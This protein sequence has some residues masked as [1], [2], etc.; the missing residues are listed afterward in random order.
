MSTH[1]NPISQTFFHDFYT[2][3]LS[4]QDPV[5]DILIV[6]DSKGSLGVESKST[7]CIVRFFRSIF[8]GTSYNLP[9]HVKKIQQAATQLLQEAASPNM[10]QE[11]VALS[12]TSRALKQIVKHVKDRKP[13][14]SS[15]E[16]D[17][18]TKQYAS[19]RQ[20]AELL[21]ISPHALA[22]S[23][24]MFTDALHFIDQTKDLNDVK[25]HFPRLLH[26]AIRKGKSDKAT[27]L[28]NQGAI[29][30]TVTKEDQL[31]YA[32]QTANQE[33][34]CRLIRSGA[35]V[36]ISVYKQPILHFACEKNYADVLRALLHHGAKPDQVD[37][38]GQIPLHLVTRAENK[39]LMTILL[40]YDA[41]ANAADKLKTGP[42]HIATQKSN[43]DLVELLLCYRANP[44]KADR[45][46][47]TAL[48]FAA[49]GQNLEIVKLLLLNGANINAQTT[50]EATALHCAA[51]KAS[52][53]IC[54]HLLA[55]GIDHTIE[56]VNG[57]TAL[58]LPLDRRYNL[59]NEAKKRF[60]LAFFGHSRLVSTWLQ[61]N[62]IGY[63][64]ITYLTQ[65][66]R[67]LV[68]EAK[69][70]RSNPYEF[71]FI[72]QDVGLTRAISSTMSQREF[73]AYLESL[74]K[75]HPNSSMDLIEFSPFEINPAHFTKGNLNIRVPAP[76]RN[77][78]L[79]GFLT[80]FDEL[81]TNN[82]DAQ[83]FFDLHKV[84]IDA[85]TSN[86]ARLREILQAMILKVKNRTAFLGTPREGSPALQEFY[87]NIDN[88]LKNILLKLE[89]LRAR[90]RVAYKALQQAVMFDILCMMN[91]CGGRYFSVS[92]CG[93]L[94]FAR[95][96][97]LTFA[98]DIYQSLAD[99]REVLMQATIP[100]GAHS[101]HDYNNLVRR[102]GRKYGLPGYQVF[103]SFDDPFQHVDVARS[104][105]QFKKSY[106]TKA[107]VKEWL[108]GTFTEGT[109]RE[110]YIDWQ[111]SQNAKKWDL[112][113]YAPIS[114]HVAILIQEKA[115]R[116]TIID[117]LAK[118]DI[119]VNGSDQNYQQAIDQDQ[120][121]AYIAANIMDENSG[122][123][124]VEA[125]YDMLVQMQ[126]LT[127]YFA[128]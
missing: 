32:M 5:K 37:S 87:Q 22:C 58:R 111:K 114:A 76:A 70:A 47:Y 110:K 1:F 77:I 119:V 15:A 107:I 29:L 64:F 128:R 122:A 78:P 61:S 89:E 9:N 26:H 101:V 35:R 21:R 27:H 67:D 14:L 56:D 72:L 44:N 117:Y 94:K 41:D 7:W 11:L 97:Q 85:G 42:L 115:T 121:Y 52:I 18:R 86:K 19:L 80:H 8:W 33:E 91:H 96:Q 95:G 13:L 23:K 118:N 102:I 81:N 69:R 109:Y 99:F 84:A 31:S 54:Q 106:I 46:G 40:E 48:H 103:E 36:D 108:S 68:T 43:H 4:G 20:A 28:L 88:A 39:T 34:A 73:R 10:S 3:C 113:R 112:A 79:E 30:A 17:L 60:Y 12:K 55:N 38:H 98:D 24:G 93:Y 16:N 71:P 62:E 124:K 126:V 63:N 51:A 6:E 49:E 120:A 116:D 104:E 125:L 75:A 127:A 66:A 83:N 59:A 65:H 2:N 57:L 100:N 45:F 82:P 25:E 90:D 74:A 92:V 105:T 53:D 50:K 123:L